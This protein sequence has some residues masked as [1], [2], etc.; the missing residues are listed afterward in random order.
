MKTPRNRTGGTAGQ[1]AASAFGSGAQSA[2]A[3]PGAT[4]PGQRSKQ[5]A[6]I[7][8]MNIFIELLIDMIVNKNL[9]GHTELN[10]MAKIIKQQGR[11]QLA[12][13]TVRY[14]FNA[15][16]LQ[17]DVSAK[18][19]TLNDFFSCDTINA[20]VMHV[21]QLMVQQGALTAVKAY[22]AADVFEG[23]GGFKNVY[24]LVH[25]ITKSNLKED[26]GAGKPAQLLGKTVEILESL[27]Q[28]RPGHIQSLMNQRNLFGLL[29]YALKTVGSEGLI[30][31]D[32]LKNL[33]NCVTN[34]ILVQYQYKK[35]QSRTIETKIAPDKAHEP[36]RL[37][38]EEETLYVLHKKTENN[39]RQVREMR[40]FYQTFL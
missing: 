10:Q 24:P 17:Q 16:G 1:D 27:L 13:E 38:Y 26:Y 34:N 14:G 4:A 15:Q 11:R 31:K 2:R 9:L 7:S 22:R 40:Q 33:T 5:G 19:Y 30:T 21:H 39:L 18:K 6:E 3:G 20:Q 35:D 29:R 8:Y 36:P 25:F 28:E 12:L 37:F 23:L 32:V